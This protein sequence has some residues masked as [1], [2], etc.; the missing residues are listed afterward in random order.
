MAHASR[1][2][3]TW[4]PAVFI[5]VIVSACCAAALLCCSWLKHDRSLVSQRNA[6]AVMAAEQRT[7]MAR[8]VAWFSESLPGE[9]GHRPATQ[10]HARQANLLD[11]A[12]IS[13]QHDRGRQ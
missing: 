7:A 4:L 6:A 11:A 8:T 13:G 3:R 12:I 9:S 5:S 1:L 10:Q 2:P